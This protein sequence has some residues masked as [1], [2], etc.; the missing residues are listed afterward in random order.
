MIVL[1]N[2]LLI[3]IGGFAGAILRYVA[4]T[5]VQT[6]TGTH[7]FPF[8]TL[9]VNVLGCFAIGILGG[10]IEHHGMLTPS[11]RL[12]LIVGILGSFTTF[13][14][15][16][17]ET[18]TLIRHHPLLLAFLYIAAQLAL[19]IPAAWIGFHLTR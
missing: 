15:F 7:A 8:G 11:M 9:S 2:L 13:S 17:F 12:L 4:S 16:S 19:G 5:A 14:S 6:L 1:K 3:G 10:M 18:L